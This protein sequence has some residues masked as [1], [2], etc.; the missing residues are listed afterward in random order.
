MYLI[1]QLL[2]LMLGTDTPSIKHYQFSLRKRLHRLSHF[3]V[4]LLHGFDQLFQLLCQFRMNR[5]HVMTV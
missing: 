1:F 3:V 2:A 5:V 4:L